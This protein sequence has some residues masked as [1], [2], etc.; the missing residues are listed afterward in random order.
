[1]RS[2]GR[3]MKEVNNGGYIIHYAASLGYHTII[4]LMQIWGL[5]VNKKSSLT[6][7][8]PLLVAVKPAKRTCKQVEIVKTVEVL[9]QRGADASVAVEPAKRA[10]E[11]V[12]IVN[13]V[14]VL[15]QCG[16][17]ESVDVE[18]KAG[19][20]PL[21]IAVRGGFEKVV[22]QLLQARADRHRTDF[23]G[24]TILHLATK[25]NAIEVCKLIR[26]KYNE[27]F[28]KCVFEKNDDGR[29]PIHL[30][31]MHGPEC[32]Q[33]IFKDEAIAVRYVSMPD[34]NGYSPL[35][36]AAKAGLKATF[37]S[38]WQKMDQCSDAQLK[39]ERRN[40]DSFIR[41]VVEDDWQWEMLA[42]YLRAFAKN[43]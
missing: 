7:G 5:D 11:Q 33:E 19:D 26:E 15:F 1:M 28:E 35:D 23:N 3:V 31:A 42:D 8:T 27:E 12:E 4:R 22:E 30:A 24:N 36:I 32:F 6:G 40:L 41:N 20:T 39:A 9:F 18:N 37:K 43:M 10:C 34:D 16:A 14:E 13:A 2:L 17:G 21:F 38:M 25:V 29:T